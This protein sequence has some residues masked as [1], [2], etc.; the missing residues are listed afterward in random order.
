MIEL[1]REGVRGDPECEAKAWLDKLPETDRE[2]RGYQRLAAKGLVSDEELDE[3]LQSWKRLAPRRS[4][5]WRPLRASG[6]A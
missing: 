5:S 3:A 4:A 6:N 1:E 2:R